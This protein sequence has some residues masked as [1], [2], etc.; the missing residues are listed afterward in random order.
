VEPLFR[1][2]IALMTCLGLSV[3]TFA[4]GHLPEVAQFTPETWTRLQP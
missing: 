4:Q 3:M 1:L 2:F